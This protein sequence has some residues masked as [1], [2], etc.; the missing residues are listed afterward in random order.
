MPR[1]SVISV[2]YGLEDR[3]NRTFLQNAVDSLARQTDRDFEFI[4]VDNS[5]TDGGLSDLDVSG[6]P[7]VRIVPWSGNHG[8]AKG[9]NL[10]A[11]M[12]EGDW[13]ILLNPDAV[14]D[15]DWISEIG[16]GIARYP[17]VSM[18][19]SLQ[20]SLEDSQTLDGAGDAYFGP[21]FAWRGGFGRPVSEVPGEGTCFSPCGAGAVYRRD[22]FLAVGGFDEDFFCF[23]EDTDLAY[24]LRLQ[25]QCCVFLPGARIQHAGG[26]VSGRVSDFAVRHGARN[27]IWGYVKTTPPLLLWLTLPLHMVFTIAILGRGLMTGRF[28]ATLGGIRE[29][30][31]GLGTMLAKRKGIQAERT[32]SSAQLAKA[33]AWNPL[34]MLGRK[35]DV[36]P[37]KR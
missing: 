8:F 34:A 16:R 24:R 18:F 27:R 33:M 5:E 29:G 1:F 31:S 19:A 14:A 2:A 4:L 10:A 35:V 37:V 28:N 23:G 22:A 17:V 30:L 21:G 26:G 13:L 12:A 3:A 11:G 9:N 25:G 32:A 7:R 6:V 20:V 15:R 36:R